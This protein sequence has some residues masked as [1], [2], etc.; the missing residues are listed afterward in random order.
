[1]PA[2]NERSTICVNAKGSD[3]DIA[4]G[5]YQPKGKRMKFKQ[6]TC[7]G[8]NETLVVNKSDVKQTK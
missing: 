2:T 5:I 8:F 3:K 1:M 4:K 7:K 6:T